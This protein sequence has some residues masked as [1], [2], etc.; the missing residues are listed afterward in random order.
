M[1][2]NIGVM[3]LAGFVALFALNCVATLRTL[4]D[5]FLTRGQRIGQIAMTWCLP[6]VG[7]LLVIAL[8]RRDVKTAA[9]AY[10]VEKDVG[11]QYVISGRLNEQ[12]YIESP[13]DHFGQSDGADASPD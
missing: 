12:G 3:L 1:I 11:A 13:A 5:V 9:G 7:A 6:V 10:R 4:Q 8:T 2:S